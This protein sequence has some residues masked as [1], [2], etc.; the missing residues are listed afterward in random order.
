MRR[1]TIVR[2]LT[3]LA[4]GATVLTGTGIAWAHGS[5]GAANL[6]TA[7][8]ELG[9][10]TEVVSAT[11]TASG[12]AGGS[13]AFGV[14]GPIDDVEVEPGDVV[15]AG[16]VLARM[17]TAAL[18]AAVTAA[19]ATLAKAEAALEDAR[20]ALTEAA[21]A[22]GAGE[23]QEAAGQTGAPNLGTGPSGSEAQPD[24]APQPPAVDLTGPTQALN[25]AT[26]AATVALAAA[27]SALAA[28][29]AACADYFAGA[30]EPA[31]GDLGSE[32]ERNDATASSTTSSTAAL[33]ACSEALTAVAAAQAGVAAAQAAVADAESAYRTA[34]DRALAAATARAKA[35]ESATQVA[36]SAAEAAKRQL[37]QAQQAAQAQQPAQ[38]PSSRGDAGGAGRS[39]ADLDA[40]VAVQE[41]AVR[42][43]E[44]ELQGAQQDRNSAVLTA[45]IDGT[46]AQ[47]PFLEG[48]RA[49]AD[50][51]ISILGHGAMKVEVS[52]P[53]ATAAE[54]KTG[55]A[56]AVTSDGAEAPSEATVTAIGILPSTQGGTT[57]P[58][59]LTVPNPAK[60]LAEGAAATVA[61]ALRVARGVATVPNSALAA[62]GN[63]STASVTLIED[64]KPVRRQVVVGAVG[65]SATEIAEGL[66]VG[67][68]V[69]LADPSTEVPTS[70]TASTRTVGPGG[71]GGTGSGLGG[72]ATL[73]PRG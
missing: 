10:V 54:L 55:M 69:I 41:A 73:R 63:G 25:A 59:V 45:P 33:E 70:S 24:D 2:R 9:D 32:S 4:L 37:A 50:D 3:S 19:Q 72:G 36:L 8:V 66:T 68:V 65:H 23:V 1:P 42:V 44:A 52:V 11:G 28:Q 14:A 21:E 43:A 20:Q 27:E 15:Q 7:V 13:A 47:V 22:E 64:G 31:G 35:A 30:G 62:T 56:A 46:V 57:Y 6:R 51:A 49:S 61:I 38:A 26:T 67:Q 53:S 40:E 16:D 60:G 12:L 5:D 29:Q 17:D 34:V 48:K 18:D 71:F 39:K 58:V